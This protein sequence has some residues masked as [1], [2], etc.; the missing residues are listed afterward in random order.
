M[1]DARKRARAD[2]HGSQEW[3]EMA[4]PEI[5]YQTHNKVT[6]W[7]VF[8]GDVKVGQGGGGGQRGLA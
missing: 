4:L 6:S 2:V 8:Y 7:H 3:K 5:D 1:A